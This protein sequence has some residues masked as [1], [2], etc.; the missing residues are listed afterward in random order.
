MKPKTVLIGPHAIEVHEVATLTDA[1]GQFLADPNPAI[2]IS[3]KLSPK[4]KALTIFHECLHC[5]FYF[6]GID[7]DKPVDEEH[8]VRMLESTVPEL[9]RRNKAIF[10]ELT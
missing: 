4:E 5:L 1:V 3:S 6:H 8:V 10:K 9:L 2:H 7:F